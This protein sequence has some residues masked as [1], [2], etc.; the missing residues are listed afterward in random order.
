M[1]KPLP[2]AAQAV[3]MSPGTYLRKRREAAGLSLEL[4]ALAF[5]PWGRPVVFAKAW[6]ISDRDELLPMIR[7][8]ANRID[9]LERDLWVTDR[10]FTS[11][12][13]RFIPLDVEI[14]DRLTVLTAGIDIGMPQICKSCGWT[15]AI[16]ETYRVESCIPG[17]FAEH[18]NHFSDIDPDLCAA[19]AQRA[20]DASPAPIMEVD[21]AS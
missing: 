5:V 14:Y 3:P 12:L 20:A 15:W 10:T 2:P 11:V 8:V 13:A 9:E 17:C 4:A 19:C 6:T 7:M 21:N 18:A 1:I 16:A